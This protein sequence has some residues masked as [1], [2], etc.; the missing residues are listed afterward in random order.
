MKKIIILII[1]ASF[2]VGW[3][4]FILAKNKEN[5]DIDYTKL[6]VEIENLENQK[7]DQEINKEDQI[8]VLRNRFSLRG[9]IMK[10]D[11]YFDNNQLMLALNEYLK[12]YRESPWD[13]KIIE[14]IWDV[15]FELKNFSK[16]EEFFTLINRKDD[17]ITE[18]LISSIFYQIDFSQYEKIK[19]SVQ[20]IKDLKLPVE[21]QFY[22]MNS[23]NCSVN[24]HECKKYFHNYFNKNPEISFSKL[25]NIKDAFTTFENF[26]SENLYYKDALMIGAFFRN[27]MYSLSNF[28]WE[29]MLEEKSDYQPILL[30][31]WK[32]QYELWNLTQAQD[33]LLQYYKI[34]PQD[35]SIAYL[36]GNIY[37][38]QRD[39]TSSNLYYNVALRNNFEPKI[40]LQRKLIYN[41]YLLD[42][43]RSMLNLF[44][45]LLD[46]TGA[47]ME[48]YSLWIYHAILM[49]RT[50]NASIWAKRWI[51]KFWDQQGREVFYWYLWW[52]EREAWNLEKAEEYIRNWLQINPRNPLLTLNYWY[53]EKAKWNYP[54]AMIYLKRTVN[55]NGEWEFW[56][57]AQKEI[58]LLESRMQQINQ[59]L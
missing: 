34:N 46:E 12:A 58:I 25:N 1:T 27:K 57:L 45:Y 17:V 38:R 7:Q 40:E 30:M 54:T 37:F 6:W 44:S 15:Y 55:F 19:E 8:N 48:D 28:L 21:Q 51:E 4:F 33:F 35:I 31:V 14:K 50:A 11:N 49:W 29:K 59:D 56:E 36:L 32:W 41:H 43:K 20:K 3:I 39:Y 13:D 22:Y 10:W 47:N 2:I 53:I 5:F 23:L 52:I 26:Q 16:A 9:I 18:K 42:D 24:L